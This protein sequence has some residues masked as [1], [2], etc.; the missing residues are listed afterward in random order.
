VEAFDGVRSVE[1]ITA[2][3][4]RQTGSG[5]VT[6]GAVETLISQLEGKALLVG[7]VPGPPPRRLLR[8]ALLPRFLL[9]KRFENVLRPVSD[10]VGRL[11]SGPAA[12]VAVTGA[13]AGFGLA[14]A[15]LAHHAVQPRTVGVGV[16]VSAVLVQL[17]AVFL[18]ESWHGIMATRVG[19][20]VR[21]LGVALLFWVTPVA[22]VDRTDSYRVRSRRGRAAIAVA[23]MVSDGWV[24]GVMALVAIMSSGFWATTALLV[25]LFQATMLVANLNPLL[26]SDTVA[27][28]EAATGLVDVRGRAFTLVRCRLRRQPVPA[29]LRALPRRSMRIYLWYGILCWGMVAVIVTVAAVNMLSLAVLTVERVAG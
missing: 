5:K 24:S 2:E 25:L 20:P 7:G 6:E 29:Y 10:L 8:N 18:H 9:W 15:V 21:G 19:S 12:A 11:P 27:A 1:Q 22:Y 16:L 13:L 3:L 26:P 23:G 28:I 14:G 17:F 4:A